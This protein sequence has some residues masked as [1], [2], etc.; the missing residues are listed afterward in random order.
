MFKAF[1]EA[2]MKQNCKPSMRITWK[3]IERFNE[4]LINLFSTCK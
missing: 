1:F 3:L 4:C 2:I